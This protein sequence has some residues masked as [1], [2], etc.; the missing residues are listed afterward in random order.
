LNELI[1]GH[2]QEASTVGYMGRNM[3]KINAIVDQRKVDHQ[4]T[5]MEVEGKIHDN[6]IS[7]L[8]DLGDSLIY[9]TPS[10]VEL[11][12]LTKINHVKSWLV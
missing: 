3:H 11:N 8:I 10:L 5:I 1:G 12:K 2:L 6:C 4:S 9:V 7:I